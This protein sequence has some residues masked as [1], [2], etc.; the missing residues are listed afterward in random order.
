MLYPDIW[1]VMRIFDDTY[2]CCSN[3]DTLMILI[4]VV[5]LSKQSNVMVIWDA[6]HPHVTSL[7]SSASS[8]P[9]LAIMIKVHQYRNMQCQTIGRS[10]VDS[11]KLITSK[12]HW[13]STISNNVYL[14]NREVLQQNLMKTRAIHSYLVSSTCVWCSER[15][16]F[17]PRV[18]VPYNAHRLVA[19]VGIV[20]LVTPH[21][22][23]VTR[24][25]DQVLCLD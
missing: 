6:P 14:N 2:F 8:T 17:I 1:P 10:S 22:C 12:F 5:L 25:S 24:L 18:T 4:F 21:S 9:K 3:N 13:L 19:I 20:I 11:T 15:L 16:P 23:Q 7:E